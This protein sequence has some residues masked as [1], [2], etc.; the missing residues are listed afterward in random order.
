MSAGW[1]AP[2]ALDAGWFA[3]ETRDKG[4]FDRLLLEK[5]GAAQDIQAPLVVNDAA[6]YYAVLYSYRRGI[7]S[8]K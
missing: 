2:E 6:Y 1:F 7:Y 3:Q 5:T 8:I 4:W